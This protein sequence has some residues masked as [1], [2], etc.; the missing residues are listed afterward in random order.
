MI[1]LWVLQDG[2]QSL[3]STRS[4]S[5]QQL[6]MALMRLWRGEVGVKLSSWLANAKEHAFNNRLLKLTEHYKTNEEH[7]RRARAE[8]ETARARLHVELEESLSD[9]IRASNRYGARMESRAKLIQA[10]AVR[11]SRRIL[12]KLVNGDF[13]A[14]ITSWRLRA[15]EGGYRWNLQ[16]IKEEHE[17]SIHNIHTHMEKN[18]VT[19]SDDNVFTDCEIDPE[20]YHDLELVHDPR[21]HNSCNRCSTFC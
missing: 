16:L 8:A 18:L 10:A 21:H 12:S 17:R 1:S 7:L 20:L 2:A 5:M 6:K 9:A 13:A 11:S 3:L 4:S 15:V 19:K 14:M